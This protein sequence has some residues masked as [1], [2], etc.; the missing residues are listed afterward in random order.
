[1]ST[2]S[3]NIELPEEI[4]YEIDSLHLKGKKIEDKLKL[5]LAIGLF[6]SKDISLAKAAELAGKSLPDFIHF[7]KNFNISAIEYNQEM[8]QDDL[9]FIDKYESVIKK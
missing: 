3:I 1:M 5:N 7:L 2:K 8:Y 4:Y 9:N 6:V